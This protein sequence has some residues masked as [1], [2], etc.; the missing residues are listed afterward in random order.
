MDF[1]LF[2]YFYAVGSHSWSKTCPIVA[3]GFGK[4]R[5]ADTKQINRHGSGVNL[6]TFTIEWVGKA[7]SGMLRRVPPGDLPKEI[8]FP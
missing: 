2:P 5:E 4:R 7:I 8:T 6:Y 1:A 3:H